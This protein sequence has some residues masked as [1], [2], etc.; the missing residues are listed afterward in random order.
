MKGKSYTKELK[1]EVLREAK[2]VGNVSLV[3][4]RHGISKSTIFTWI[5][6]SKDEIKVK[7][8]RK[9]LVEGEKELENEL[10]EVTKENDHL[11]K[12]LG[13][14]DL[15]VAILRDLNK[16]IKPSIKEKVEIAKK[17]IDQGYNA[18]FVLKVVKLGRSTYYYNLSVEGKEKARPKGGKP[19][20]YSINVDGEKVCDDQI[21]EFILEAIDGDAIN[22]G[23]RKIT[24]HLRKYYNL[25]INHKKVYRL[26]KEL[27]I[28][29]DQRIIKAKI[30][31][32]IAVNRT[33]TGSNQLWEMDIKYGYI[34][35]EDK[36]FYLL[37]LIDIFD[38]SIIDYHMGLHCEAKDATALLRKCLIR[39]N[40]FEEGSK[41][42]VIRTDNGPQF[43]SHKFD[44]CCEGLKTEHERIPVKTPNKNAHVESFHRILEDECLKINEFQSYAEAYKIVN[45]FMEFYNNRRLHSSLRFMAPHEF[46]N[47]YFG[48]NL[49]NI[50]IRV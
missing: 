14:K 48:E 30:K 45:E 1:E 19:K 11:K 29:K 46:Y 23:Y 10:T 25:V 36:F 2:E 22:Y 43:I 6:N 31:R 4:R 37:N 32:N 13:E 18:V 47:L 15:E 28:L 9:A 40:L 24:Y 33:I 3:S 34:E 26:C 16:K 38:R 5:K 41:K 8:G 39:R 44:E 20:G 7:P 17:Y 49:T 21:K 12:L 50:Q 27:R 42:P 35:G